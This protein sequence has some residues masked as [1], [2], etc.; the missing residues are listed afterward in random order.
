[1]DGGQ[2]KPEDA[3][4][5]KGAQQKDSSHPECRAEQQLGRAGSARKRPIR[6]G[7]HRRCRGGGNGYA[8]ELLGICHKAART[9][10]ALGNA[11]RRDTDHEHPSTL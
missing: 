9:R 7:Q 4:Q 6:A 5:E 10:T 2:G 1:M 3:A 8:W 11:R